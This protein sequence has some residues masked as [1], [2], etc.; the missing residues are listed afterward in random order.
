MNHY[1][2]IHRLTGPAILVLLGVVALLSEAHVVHFSI[3]IPLLLILLGVLKLAERASLAGWEYPAAGA[4]AQMPGAATYGA[5]YEPG[6]AS[7]S[8]VPTPASSQVSMH[9]LSD[10]GSDAGEGKL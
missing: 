9:E 1:I 6:A 4:G 7:S 2:L 10:G 5:N 8:M 3:F